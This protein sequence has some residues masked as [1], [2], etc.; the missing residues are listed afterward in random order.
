MLYKSKRC[1][2][3]PVSTFGRVQRCFFGCPFFW[4]SFLST[5]LV[6][7][8]SGNGFGFRFMARAPSVWCVNRAAIL[9]SKVE[10]IVKFLF[11]FRKIKMQFLCCSIVLKRNMDLMCRGFSTVNPEIRFPADTKPG[12]AF[13]LNTYEK[14][15]KDRIGSFWSCPS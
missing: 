12:V 11:R 4:N 15:H 13:H 14:R 7:V 3:G 10:K 8:S 5:C 1:G 2:A 9:I 6:L